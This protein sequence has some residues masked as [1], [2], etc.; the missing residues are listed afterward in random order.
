M[1]VRAGQ[2]EDQADPVRGCAVYLGAQCGRVRLNGRAKIVSSKV[3]IADGFMLHALPDR[4]AGMSRIGGDR[5]MHV[6]SQF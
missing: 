3:K 2:P 4:E 6:D 5:S 1:E